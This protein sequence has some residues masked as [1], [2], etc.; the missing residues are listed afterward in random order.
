MDKI[1]VAALTKN[2]LAGSGVE[3]ALSLPAPTSFFNSLSR[4]GST[5]WS[6]AL[7]TFST[8]LG[9]TS[10]PTISTPLSAAIMAVGKPI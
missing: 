10:T 8:T 7:F 2:A 3:V 4:P 1:N 5:I 6:S 9:L